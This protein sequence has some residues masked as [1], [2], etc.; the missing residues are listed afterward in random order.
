MSIVKPTL[1]LSALG[2]A[3]VWFGCSSSQD[4]GEA[5]DAAITGTSCDIFDNQTGGPI[6][7]EQLAK[8]NDPIAK[9]LL[10]SEGGC[11]TT[12]TAA[13]AKLKTTD[14]K[15]CTASDG[16]G[17]FLISETA[18]FEKDTEAAASGYRTVIAKDCDK[19]GQD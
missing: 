8:L 11:P 14:N 3:S 13:L 18:A 12:Y 5:D 7:N 10:G 9:K 6:S 19:R 16:L 1:V 4:A 15:D 17:S 2:A